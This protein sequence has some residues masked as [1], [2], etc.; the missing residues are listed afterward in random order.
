[1]GVR[2]ERHQRSTLEISAW[3]KGQKGVR[4]VLNPALPD[5]PHHALFA[6]DFR[7][8]TS[9]FSIVLEGT[10]DEAGDK[11]RAHAF[12]D[13]LEVF[14]LGYS[15]GGYES[16]AVHVWLGDRTVTRKDYGGP[17]I[18]LQIGLEDVADLQEDLMRGLEAV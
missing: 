6:R 15:W 10:G 9:V 13:A 12:L 16:L 17:V 14:G 3:L 2:L 8:S 11:A 1:M 18:R 7:G 4:E 5:D